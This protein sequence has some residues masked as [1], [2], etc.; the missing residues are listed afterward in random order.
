MA[1]LSD[2]L[3]PGLQTT[4]D[5]IEGVAESAPDRV[6]L[7]APDG[8]QMS[9]RELVLSSRQLARLLL[10]RGLQPGD[11]VATWMADSFEYVQCYVACAL[12]GLVVVPINTRYTEHE[13]RHL[14]VDSGARILLHNSGETAE[15]A[16][17]LDLV[18][19]GVQILDFETDP[20]VKA[21]LAV[22][23]AGDLAEGRLPSPGPESLLVIGYTSGTTGRPKGAMLTQRSVAALARMNALSYRLPIGSVAAMTGS[24]S[25]VAVV[26]AHIMSHFYVRGTVCFLGEWTMPSLID[27]IERH[28]ATFTYV[29]SPLIDDFCDALA[30]D[31][32]RGESL[33]T[34]LHSASKA[35]PEKL[36]RLAGVIGGRFVEG[37]GMT[38]NSGGL[39]TATTP[40]DAAAGSGRLATV[41]RAVSEVEI[42]LVD[43]DGTRLP[44]DGT[45]L[46][47]LVYRSPALMSGYWGLPK[48]TKRALVDGWYHTGDLGTIDRAGYV[49][50]IERRVDLIVS[51]GMNV[52]PSEV[53]ECLAAHPDVDA[54]C[55]VGLPHHRWGQSVAAV[56]VRRD[57]ATVTEEQLLHYCRT[58]LASYKK[59]TRVEF[60]EHLP[61]TQSLKISRHQ[62]RKLFE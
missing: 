34:V 24:M 16:A 9:Y 55:V 1:G 60:V 47:E 61:T 28:R 33:V 53:E 5:L 17:R 50:L 41:G 15:R 11:R 12:A 56:V 62:V 3:V 35:A 39:M 51:G 37:W 2:V 32:E 23:A 21:T 43:A 54:C 44:H 22:V 4:A 30:K 38:E 59:P 26:P 14:V 8:R 52:Y 25:F 57:G 18:D 10:A 49:T 45:T 46:G 6:A 42:D 31:P 29:P 58:Y 36:E 19:S 40:A 7:V 27:S 13:A 48:E 20:E